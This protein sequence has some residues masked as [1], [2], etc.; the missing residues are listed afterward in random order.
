MS[1][2]KRIS[3]LLVLF[4]I[5]LILTMGYKGSSPLLIFWWVIFGLG[6]LKHKVKPSKPHRFL[7]FNEWAILLVPMPLMYVGMFMQHP[8][9]GSYMLNVGVFG[10]WFIVM[11]IAYMVNRN[12]Y[13]LFWATVCLLLVLGNVWHL[14]SLWSNLASARGGWGYFLGCR[15]ALGTQ[16]FRDYCRLVW[17]WWDRS[18]VGLCIWGCRWWFGQ[19]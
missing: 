14:L 3:I 15:T 19:H 6:A 8:D 13:T 16:C 5:L 7:N 12:R 2:L 1:S 4:S 18:Q 10:I 11:T 9:P 17:G